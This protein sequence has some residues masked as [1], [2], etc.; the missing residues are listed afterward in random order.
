[1][2]SIS[3]YCVAAMVII[4]GAYV[5]LG[6]VN[7]L[8]GYQP[9]WRALP[10]ST[11]QAW[12]FSAANGTNVTA[13]LY[14]NPNGTPLA[15]VFAGT[16]SVGWQ[17]GD[18]NDPDISYST[19][20]A[21]W[22]DLGGDGSGA[23]TVTIPGA[24]GGFGATR[25]IWLQVTAAITA[26]VYEPATVAVAGGTQIG[27]T[28][29]TAVE[30]YYEQGAGQFVDTVTVYQSQWQV[31]GNTTFDA[32]TIT[33]ATTG[34][35]DSVIG[36]VVVD[37][38]VVNAAGAVPVGAASPAGNSLVGTQ[39]SCR[40]MDFSPVGSYTW[41]LANASGTAGTDWD[42]LSLS[43]TLTVS[44]TPSSRF[45]I[46][47]TGTAASFNNQNL[48][49]YTWR[50]VTATDTITTFDASK[51]TVDAS[52]FQNFLGGG[53]FSVALSADAKGLDLTFTPHACAFGDITRGWTG[54]GNTLTL[55]Y[56]NVYGLKSVKGL[57]ANNCSLTYTA[58]GDV[59][60]TVVLAGPAALAVAP[61]T[62]VSLPD[63]TI[64][65]VV[66][67]TRPNASPASCNAEVADL[68]SN[69]LSFDPVFTVL[70]VGAS[71][72]VREVLRDIPAA[73][74]YVTVRNHT[75]GLSRLRLIVNGFTFSL[76]SLFDGETRTVDVGEAMNPGTSNTV[77]L[78]GEGPA[79]ASALVVIADSA[80][81][82]PLLLP[83]TVTLQLE[84][85]E[86]GLRL[87]WPEVAG[88]ALQSRSSLLP[89]AAWLDWLELPTLADGRYS[90]NVSAGASAQFF[91][92]AKP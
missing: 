35:K 2:K 6:C 57:L 5:A 76:Y 62:P 37:T 51:F 85:T 3:N 10:G 92:L 87:S 26:G 20:C 84:R 42:L 73:E 13:S 36:G 91:R 88:F 61:P 27:T 71:G 30:T 39:P 75:P 12:A 89:D 8:P 41:N 47:P 53:S 67:G 16:G 45:T 38:I 70:Q 24:S 23:V 40:S 49:G 25:L 56:T 14:T 33:G 69:L 44:A 9:C 7:D 15:T 4:G 77:V 50:I 11:Y 43:G 17:A 59:L 83:G 46:K 66:L 68:C 55:S 79:G 74:R 90:V 19:N 64:K 80:A 86:N 28:V 48:G 58:Y 34:G 72:E 78:V 81:G 82:E 1:M 18:I 31:S 63:G 65:V 52:Q 54:S 32:I 60:G 29:S 22:W 21:G